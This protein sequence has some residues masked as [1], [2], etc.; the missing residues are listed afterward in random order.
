MTKTQSQV[1]QFVLK[2]VLIG[3]SSVGLTHQIS[4]FMSVEARSRYTNSTGPIVII[5]ALIMSK[6][7]ELVLS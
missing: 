1:I 6:C 3:F 2:V 7:P 4:K 5:I